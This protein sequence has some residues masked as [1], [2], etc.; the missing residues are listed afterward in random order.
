M[1][2]LPTTSQSTGSSGA[3]PA[4]RGS[5]REFYVDQARRNHP[6]VVPRNDFEI[7]MLGTTKILVPG[8]ESMSTDEKYA[9]LQQ[10]WDE[11][12]QNTGSV[13]EANAFVRAF[14]DMEAPSGVKPKPGDPDVTYIQIPGAEGKPAPGLSLRFWPG[15]L[16]AA[17]YCMDFV[18]S[19]TKK[20]V[21][22]PAQY[23]LSVL[24]DPWAG[25]WDHPGRTLV[26][27][28]RAHRIPPDQILEGEEKYILRDGLFCQLCY[29]GKAVMRF[30]VPRRA[31]AGMMGLVGDDTEILSPS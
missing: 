11:L 31:D 29:E 5:S 23:S 22:V 8:Q 24:S 20:P 14:L 26:S 18:E 1:D 12:V 13:D 17:E 19:A 28:E 25:P 9:W 7:F 6:D 15:S 27:I 3:G 30:R 2:Q 16:S 10:E 4:Q 21:N